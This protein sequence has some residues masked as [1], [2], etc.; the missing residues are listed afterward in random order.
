VHD[1][2]HYIERTY[3]HLSTFKWC[4]DLD[5][6]NLKHGMAPKYALGHHLASR[7]TETNAG[8]WRANATTK[9]FILEAWSEGCMVGALMI[10]SFVTIANMRRRVLLHK[11]IL[12]EVGRHCNCN[13]A[14][15]C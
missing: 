2:G 1:G 15:Y 13:P 6:F 12:L 10:M 5:L 9:S 11:L 8:S 14:S 3:V 4:D 7:A